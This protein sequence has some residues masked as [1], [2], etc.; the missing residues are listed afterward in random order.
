VIGISWRNVSRDN[1]RRGVGGRVG[2]SRSLGGGG[3]VVVVVN[4]NFPQIFGAREGG[5]RSRVSARGCGPDF[6]RSN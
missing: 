4:N 2:S 6:R 3:A 5:G 1:K